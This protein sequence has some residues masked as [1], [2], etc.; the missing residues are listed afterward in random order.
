MWFRLLGVLAICSLLAGC[1]SFRPAYLPGRDAE[2]RNP[3]SGENLKSG[4]VIRVFLVSR[5]SHQGRFLA[6][7]CDS[8][9]MSWPTDQGDQNLTLPL[10]EIDRIEVRTLTDG[11]LASLASIG[12]LGGLGLQVT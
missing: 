6:F 3:A 10:A 4:D 7:V 12:I 5:E 1:G 2:T 11:Q 9:Q 8:L